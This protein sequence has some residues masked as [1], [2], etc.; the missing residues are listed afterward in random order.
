[1]HVPSTCP[2][3]KAVFD[4]LRSRALIVAAGRVRAFCSDACRNTAELEDEERAHAVVDAVLADAR[5]PGGRRWLLLGGLVGVVAIAVVVFVHGRSAHRAQPSAQA[6]LVESPPLSIEDAMK[7]LQ[8]SADARDGVPISEIPERDLWLH[9]LAGPERKMPTRSTRRFGATRTGMR[10]DECR[11][12]HCGVDLGEQR[13]EAVFAAHD[14]VVERVVEEDT[15]APGGRYVRLN[16]RGGTIT[17]SYMHLDSIRAGL[18]PGVPVKAGDL[19]G[20][21]GD[22]GVFHSGPH[23]HFQIGVRA[24]PDAPELFI[25]PEPLLH[26]WAL[27]PPLD[28]KAPRH[29][30]RSPRVVESGPQGM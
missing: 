27:R 29:L 14:G 19:L 28:P 2:V 11:S 30:A 10:P 7:L 23:L 24:R 20:S 21:V 5:G 16:H 22:T 9:P 6:A 1:M 12:G 4:P 18:H 26:L 15:G 8:A 3:C 17:T 25:D 13:G